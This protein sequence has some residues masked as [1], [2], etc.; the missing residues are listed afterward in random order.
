MRFGWWGPHISWYPM[1][2]VL[3]PRHRSNWFIYAV[4][5]VERHSGGHVSRLYVSALSISQ[6]S[7]MRQSCSVTVIRFLDSNQ[8]S[9]CAQYN[10]LK[11]IRIYTIVSVCLERDQGLRARKHQPLA[12]PRKVL[13]KNLWFQPFCWT[14][15]AGQR[16][17]RAIWKTRAMRNIFTG[18]KSV[19]NTGMSIRAIYTEVEF[20]AYYRVRNRHDG[21]R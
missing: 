4:T 2:C 14:L 19:E 17:I 10:L 1:C 13:L 3:L 16:G 6:E 5:S 20:S 7:P 18:K 12:T 8:S 9:M 11:V 21:H 15:W